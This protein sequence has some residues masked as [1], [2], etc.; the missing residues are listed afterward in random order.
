MIAPNLGP[1]EWASGTVPTP[2]GPIRIEVVRDGAGARCEV[3]EIPPGI[4][5]VEPG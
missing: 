1:L 2:E 5:V 4:T 3:L